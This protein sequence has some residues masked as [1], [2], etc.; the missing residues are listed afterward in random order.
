[1]KKINC[2][3]V[4]DEKNVCD[5]LELLLN[6]LPCIHVIKKFYKSID[7][8]K[9]IPLLKPD[10]VFI[11]IEMPI[12]NGF[13]VIEEIRKGGFNTTYIFATGHDHYILKAL[14]KSAFDYILKPVDIDELKDVVNRFRRERFDKKYNHDLL[15]NLTDRE[16]EVVELVMEGYSSKQIAEKL[17]LSKATIDSHRRNILDKLGCRSFKE[18]IGRLMANF[19]TTDGH[20]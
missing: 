15:S 4:D 19:S 10:L 12:V 9:E 17:F 16:T 3:I 5:K 11:D 2:I 7:A 8:I 18:V 1:M 13:D 14:R 20:R 6:M